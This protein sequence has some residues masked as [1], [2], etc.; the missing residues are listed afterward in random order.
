MKKIILTLVA[1]MAIHAASAQSLLDK[2]KSAAQ[3]SQTSASSMLG[4]SAKDIMAKLGPSLALSAIQKPKVLEAVSSFAGQ[5]AQILP[6]LNTDK[7]AYTSKLTGLQNTLF[8]KLK[9]ILTVAQ[10]SKFL[11]LK[12]KAPSAT[13][14]LSAL[15]F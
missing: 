1:A 10:Y 9:T 11:G 6:L 2:A 7:A 8:P 15:F 4:A 13:D 14:A 5:K 12:P 3:T